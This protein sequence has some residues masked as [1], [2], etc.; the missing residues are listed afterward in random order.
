MAVEDLLLA[1]KLQVTTDVSQETLP[2]TLDPGKIGSIGTDLA[3]ILIPELPKQNRFNVGA[4]TSFPIG[5]AD[6]DLYYRAIV[7]GIQILRNIEGVWT[8]LATIP[9]GISLPDGIFVGLRTSI[10]VDIVSV[11]S[12]A[13]IISNVKYS[14]STQTQFTLAAKHLSFDR[15][16]LIYA[17]TNNQILILTGTPTLTPVKPTIPAN[18][19]VVDYAYIP[20]IGSPYLL[21]GQ[22]ISVTSAAPIPAL[23]SSQVS[24]IFTLTWNSARVAQFGVYGRF[25]VEQGNTYQTVP[26]TIIKD[27]S[28]NN[29]T[30][31]EFDLSNIDSLIHII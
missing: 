17:D 6:T 16:D 12:G 1:Y 5:G 7:N 10:L 31:Y 23:T 30:A 21:A 25:L 28:T 18:C 2:D 22:S 9:I 8:L 11:T 24:G 20:A 19:I 4:G 3:D 14:K 26:I 13:W 29:P 15:W 27:I